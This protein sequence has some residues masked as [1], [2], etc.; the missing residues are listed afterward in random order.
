[1][2][3]ARANP[4][5]TGVILF[6]SGSYGTP[7]GAVL[8]H[9]NIVANVEQAH[10]HIPFDPNWS[11]FCPLPMFHCFGLT[12]GVMLPI[13]TGH[14]TFLFPS[15][16]AVKEIPKLISE[17]GANVFF[18]TDTFAQQYAR[19][20]ADGDLNCIQ[21]HG[22]RRRAR[23]AGDA[24]ALQDAASMSNCWKATARPKPRR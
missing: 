4:D 11:F 14:K 19:N 5:D 23:E 12:G 22:L 1:M 18:A 10:T 15:P 20:A 8:S 2:F 3:A 24:R 7:K 9:A 17:T 16:L 13:F 21:T 6:T